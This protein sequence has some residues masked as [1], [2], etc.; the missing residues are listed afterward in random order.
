V[1]EQI[2]DPVDLGTSSAIPLEQT[3]AIPPQGKVPITESLPM[4][5]FINTIV[6]LGN[7]QLKILH[8]QLQPIKLWCKLHLHT[9]DKK[10]L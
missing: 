4:I 3:V 8:R 7:F 10:L 6:T 2:T 5:S 1:S 9:R